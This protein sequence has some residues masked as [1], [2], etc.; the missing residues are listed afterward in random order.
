M[1]EKR[2]GA[3]EQGGFGTGSTRH[4]HSAVLRAQAA[5]ARLVQDVHDGHFELVPDTAVAK[6]V[7]QRIKAVQEAVL[8]CYGRLQL[9]E[10]VTVVYRSCSTQS[11]WK[12]GVEC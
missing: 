6:S 2:R 9:Q 11:Q 7:D 10:F 12:V 1:E 8:G 5:A 4:T 3:V